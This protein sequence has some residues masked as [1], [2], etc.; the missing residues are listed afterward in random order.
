MKTISLLIF[1]SFIFTLN[2]L[3]NDE[4]LINSKISSVNTK[5]KTVK[6]KA[7]AD[8]KE[9]AVATDENTII[10]ETRLQTNFE[11]FIESE[12]YIKLR[13]PKGSA[14]DLDKSFNEISI[15]PDRKE[16]QYLNAPE[17]ILG[18]L[19][20]TSISSGE[21]QIG[22]DVKTINLA[23][24]CQ[25][26]VHE[27]I[28]LSKFTYGDWHAKILAKNEGKTV[29][30][31][32]II[33]E[34]LEKDDP[35]LPR[36]LIIGDSISMNYHE[37]AKEALKGV[38]NFHRI[39]ENG[40]PTSNGVKQVEH[41]LGKYKQKGLQWDI[42]QFNHGL[43]DL[44]K[45]YD[46]TTKIWGAPQIEIDDYKQNLEK[47]IQVLEKSGATLIWC[48]TTPVPNDIIGQFSR[49]K[50]DSALYNQAA[51]EV[52]KNH[53]AILINDLHASVENSTVF[54]A[55]KKTF[56]VHF[57]KKEEKEFLGKKVAEAIKNAIAVRANLKK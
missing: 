27:T 36:V 53:P 9:T 20:V 16:S 57:Y 2:L 26:K 11:G 10:E 29:K 40:G 54:D 33:A 37:T 52:M 35:N 1:I 13:V 12:F 6:V 41:W 19:K 50:D 4:I 46:K 48:S 47:I 22:K 23:E 15:F 51:L 49:K 8:E 14:L 7:N 28:P 38:A 34:N 30:A 3:S 24:A 44:K 45:T 25:V 5:N 56:D 39:D 42:I 21:L 55:W 32:E 17:N 31:L 18:K 43:H